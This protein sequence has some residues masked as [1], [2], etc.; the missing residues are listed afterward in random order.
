MLDPAQLAA[1]AVATLSPYFF[2]AA[3]GAAGKIGDADNITGTMTPI[4]ESGSAKHKHD[5]EPDNFSYTAKL[6]T[7][8]EGKTVS[9]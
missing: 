5:A 8:E 4:A 2:E 6:I 9:L 1:A 3:K 7:L